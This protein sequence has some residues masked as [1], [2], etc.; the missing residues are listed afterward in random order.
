MTT[1]QAIGLAQAMTALLGV[2]MFL[3]AASR[4]RQAFAAAFA[5]LALSASIACFLLIIYCLAK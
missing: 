4:D 3:Y 2:V 5:M 1:I